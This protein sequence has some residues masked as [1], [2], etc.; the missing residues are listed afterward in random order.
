MNLLEHYIK[1]VH[2]VREYH[3]FDNEPWAK[4]KQYVEVD[5]DYICYSN[6]PQRTK[7]VFTVDEW[8]KIKYRGYYMG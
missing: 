6:T 1:K 4:G 3:E 8:E 5:L 2:S 7:L